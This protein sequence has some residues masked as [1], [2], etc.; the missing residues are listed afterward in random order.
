MNEESLKNIQM[1][2]DRG[3]SVLILTGSRMKMPQLHGRHLILTK[4]GVLME[5]DTT[6]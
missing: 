4:A 5:R 1:T 2:A 3:I 6:L